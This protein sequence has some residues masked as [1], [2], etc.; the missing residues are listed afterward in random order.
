MF[1]NRGRTRLAALAAL[2]LILIASLWLP[3]VVRW[4]VPPQPAASYAQALERVAQMQARDR[5]PGGP[6][7]HPLCHTA[8]L[9]HGQRTPRAIVFLHGL[10]ACPAQFAPLADQFYA[11]GYNV[12][13]PRLPYHGLA[14]A[15]TPDLAQLT[16][17]NLLQAANEAVDAARG[18]GDEVIVAGFSMGGTTAA[19]LAQ[20]R[21]EI[22]H[23]ALLSPFLSA[24]AIPRPLLQPVTRIG[25]LLPN[26]FLWWNPDL[27]E[28]IPIQPYAYPRF[29][30]RSVAQIVRLGASVRREARAAA[31]QVRSILVITNASPIE[32]VDNT[33]TREL[34]AAWQ[35]YSQVTVKAVALP[36]DLA[37]EHD[38]IRP[39]PGGQPVDVEEVVH[40]FLVEQIH[41]LAQRAP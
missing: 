22:D 28:A 10:T 24:N 36:A 40:P 25:L 19:W 38:Y 13:I 2:V 41:G 34:A 1:A 27:K 29:G 15:M 11:L 4:D 14:D 20:H 17:E 7:I 37:L 35:Q 6:A 39:L 31:P 33:V 3:T 16:A 32:V 9:T 21:G 23:V 8:L 26:R 12:L 5:A 30:T 18:L